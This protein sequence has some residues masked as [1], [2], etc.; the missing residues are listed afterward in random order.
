M[1]LSMNLRV[2]LVILL[3]YSYLARA[4]QDSISQDGAHCIPEYDL[5]DQEEVLA[6]EAYDA[7]NSDECRYQLLEDHFYRK[8]IAAYSHNMHQ[9]IY[10][11]L[12]LIP[13]AGT[14]YYFRNAISKIPSFVGIGGVISI[15]Q[16]LAYA[17]ING[18]KDVT[19]GTE[20]FTRLYLPQSLQSKKNTLEKLE[21]DFIHRKSRLPANLHHVIQEN[22]RDMFCGDS[23]SSTYPRLSNIIAM[24]LNLP[25][26]IKDIVFEPATIHK[27]LTGYSPRVTRDLNRYAIRLV[28]ACR[29]NTSVRKIAAYF[30]GEPGVGK[31][32]AAHL[33]AQ[34]FGLPITTISLAN[35][36]A[37][38][39]MGTNKEPGLLLEAL[40]RAKLP[41]GQKYKNAIL[42]I[43]DADRIINNDDQL[44]SV[45]LTLLEPETRSFYSPYLNTEVDISNLNIILA[46][47]SLIEDAALLSRLAV[48]KFERYE[49]EYKKKVVYDELFPDLL[50]RHKRSR[51]PLS[52]DD[53]GTEDWNKIDALVYA[54]TEPGFRSLKLQL[55]AYFEDKV[56]CKYF[57]DNAQQCL[58]EIATIS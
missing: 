53:F 2:I 34:S 49:A 25:D 35:I 52:A 3:G 26:T 48:V 47:N 5:Y 12:P 4:D 1:Q 6:S 50:E 29:D 41:D 7:C 40:T 51:Y 24:A 8:K 20:A 10:R 27:M 31:T 54:N 42:L 16:P 44:A 43:D 56:L 14:L 21:I 23:H 32:R 38:K 13:V 46:G 45:L 58:Q 55:M 19:Y 33:I 30:Y 22:F 36:D 18:F 17:G 15:A 11:M 9:A 57:S 28:A 37:E 39:L